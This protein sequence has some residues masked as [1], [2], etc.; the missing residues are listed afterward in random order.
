VTDLMTSSRVTSDF[1]KSL[2]IAL[3]SHSQAS[4]HAS[5][6]R[7]IAELFCTA[8]ENSTS[9]YKDDFSNGHK[10]AWLGAFALLLR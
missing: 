6:K 10:L 2:Q 8:E 4:C 5:F 7:R 9:Y 3:A 1:V